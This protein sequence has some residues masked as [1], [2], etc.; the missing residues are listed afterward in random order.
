MMHM[1]YIDVNAAAAEMKSLSSRFLRVKG[2]H[3]GNNGRD[4]KD[5]LGHVG[6]PP[7]FDGWVWPVG[8]G[9]DCN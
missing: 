9:S 1:P 4:Q 7:R 6:S 3:Q 8:P 2:S 5:I